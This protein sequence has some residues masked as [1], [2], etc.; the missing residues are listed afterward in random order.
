MSS[1]FWWDGV[2]SGPRV[3]TGIALFQAELLLATCM[4][5]SCL[6][7]SQDFQNRVIRRR[8]DRGLPDMVIMDL[9]LCRS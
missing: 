7:G 6:L 4:S 8:S 3:I 1:I 9:R 2:Q 5:I